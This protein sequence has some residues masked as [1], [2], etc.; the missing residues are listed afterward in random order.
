MRE[1]ID[2]PREHAEGTAGET[3]SGG[4]ADKLERIA[5]SQKSKRNM[6]VWPEYVRGTPNAVLRSALFA[7]IQGKHR[8]AYKRRTLMASING[9]EVR[10][11]GIQ[12]DQSDL[13]VWMEIVHLS[14]NQMPGFQVVFNANTLLKA[15]CRSTGKNDYEWLKE[16]MSRLG[17]AFVE[18]TVRGRHTFGN[19]GFLKFYRDEETRKYVVELSEPILQ[20]F[21]DGYTHIS[22]EQRRQLRRQPLALWLHGF[23]ASHT[24]PYPIKVETIHRICGSENKSK[25]GFKRQVVRALNA[26]IVVEAIDGYRIGEDGLINVVKRCPGEQKIPP[27]SK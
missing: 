16:S 17:G 13:D 12:L 27:S 23:Y 18:I 21:M 7:G 20:M 4:M 5:A 6:P 2:G 9:I 26:L 1:L 11:L 19:N 3:M 22:L 8:K 10:F 14:R 25:S 24:T 15:L